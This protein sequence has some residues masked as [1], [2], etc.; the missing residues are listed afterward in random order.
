MII[1]KV[2]D[3]LT[4]GILNI[5]EKDLKQ[6][7]KQIVFNYEDPKFSY[8]ISE[9]DN[10]IHGY[11]FFILSNDCNY[12]RKTIYVSDKKD[13]LVFLVKTNIKN[14]FGF[15]NKNIISFKID[16]NDLW[17]NETYTNKPEVIDDLKNLISSLYISNPIMI[18]D[19]FKILDMKESTK[20]STSIIIA[21]S[22]LMDEKSNSLYSLFIKTYP[23]PA[24]Y[25]E[26][27]V[28]SKYLLNR[29]S[30]DIYMTTISGPLEEHF[31]KYLFGRCIHENT[32]D[33]LDKIDLVK[34]EFTLPE[35]CKKFSLNKDYNVF[36]APS[37]V[38][39]FLNYV[40]FG[41]Y[42][43]KLFPEK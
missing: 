22:G 27:P 41:E 2:K 28:I 34:S 19:I 14:I 20:I 5:D 18:D 8:V 6:Y 43:K 33:F 21:F 37:S 1:T 30:T 9:V 15:I 4:T 24:F 39:S 10:K 11:M 26:E 17:I 7:K 38:D 29:L 12:G 16:F 42:Y 25:M 13:N 32:Y 3:F 36:S 31:I 35:G 40:T 23:D